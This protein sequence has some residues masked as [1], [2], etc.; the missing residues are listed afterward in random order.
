MDLAICWDICF[1]VVITYELE[2]VWLKEDYPNKIK[3]ENENKGANL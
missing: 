2:F 3:K 1:K